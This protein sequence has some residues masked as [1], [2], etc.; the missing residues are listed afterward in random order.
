M[1]W[2][3]ARVKSEGKKCTITLY[4][5]NP[6]KRVL[7]MNLLLYIYRTETSAAEGAWILLEANDEEQTNTAVGGRGHHLSAGASQSGREISAGS[8]RG[9]AIN[10]QHA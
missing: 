7:S 6:I 3:L 5:L 1:D 2:L 9:G 10:A 8:G 4:I